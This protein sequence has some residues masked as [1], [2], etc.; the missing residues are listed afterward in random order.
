MNKPYSGNGKPFVLALFAEGDREKV[1]PVLEELEKKQ[2]TLCGQDGRATHRQAK[3][4]C[5][6][7]VFLSENFAKDEAKQQVFFTAE[8]A[9]MPIIPVKLDDTK[10][11]NVLERSITAKNAI[12]AERYSPEELADRIAGAESLYP[13]K[14][15]AAQKKG[16]RVR[17]TLILLAALAAIAAVVMMI[18]K[19][20]WEWFAPPPPWRSGR[21]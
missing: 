16:N 7:V 2:L 20:Q 3:K 10:Q 13:P 15:T 21:C 1:L 9:Q 14:L 8:A 17:L 19:Q 6:T 11:Q 5:T 12:L 18:G 4:A